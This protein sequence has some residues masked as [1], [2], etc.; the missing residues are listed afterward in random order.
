MKKIIT[1]ISPILIL[2]A[3]SSIYFYPA[4]EGKVVN[5]HDIVQYVGA[6]KET[7]DHRKEFKEEP[8]W[9]NGLFSGMPTYGIGTVYK[10]NYIKKIDKFLK[11][12]IPRPVSYLMLN[13]LGFYLL[14]LVMGCSRWLSL[15]GS[16]AF[17]LSS[18]FFIIIYAGHNT[19][20]MAIVYMA[21]VVMGLIITYR[22]KYW[23]GGIITAFAL[24]L[25]L[26]QS[27]P[28]ITYYLAFIVMFY[29]IFQFVE[30]YKNKQLKRFFKAS[31]ILLIAAILSLG[32][33]SSNY[34]VLLEYKA[35]STR[36]HSEL[37]DGKVSGLKE[38][39]SKETNYDL[40]YITAWSYGI[41]ETLTLMIPD[42]MG[43]ASQRTPG[44]ESNVY[45]KAVARGV[46]RH[47]AKQIANSLPMYW[48]KQPF[49]SGPVY[50]GAIIC[51]L[52]VF[53][54]FVVKGKYKWWLL[55]CTLFSIFI[56]WGHNMM[57]FI[58]PFIYYFP[59]FDSFRVPAMTLVISQFTVPLLGILALKEFF[60]AKNKTSFVKPL[61]NSLY[62]TA[63][64]CLAV[65]L[66]GSSVFDF[67][68]AGD[69]RLI[70]G[71]YPEWLIEA[72]REDRKEMMRSEAFRSLL[73]IVAGFASLYLWAKQRLKTK[74]VVVALGLL[75]IV[76]MWAVDKR[77]MNNGHFVAAK[78][79]NQ[80]FS[81]TTADRQILQ[82]ADP[83]Y[84][85]FNTTINSFNDNSASYFHKNVGGYSAVKLQRYQDLIEH[86]LARG[87]QKVF[88]M[89]NTKYFI[90]KGKDGQPQAVMNPKA[91]GNA[92]FV[93]KAT[94]ARNADE[95][96]A[97]LNKFAPEKEAVVDERFSDLLSN[98]S[99]KED[100]T[101]YI[102]LSSYKANH[103]IY[104]YA[105]S[106]AQMLVFSEIYYDKGWNLYVDGKL[107]PYFRANYVLRSAILPPGNHKIE[108]RFE[109]KSYTAG[110]NVALASF[111]L[112]IAA[113]LVLIFK[114]RRIIKSFVTKQN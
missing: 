108:W 76:D 10:H 107:H 75:V 11:L 97:M 12:G 35:E 111:L 67:A 113:L 102:N 32:I 78:K 45:K 7:S 99:Y 82:D 37:S 54:L 19:K 72:L 2:I 27:H 83:H 88:N 62:I 73:F 17:G 3:I 91:M 33:N 95:E 44:V 55:A 48:G 26:V 30:D 59:G 80:P 98:F 92:W 14:L 49:T 38:S 93:E 105:S 56:A 61:K 89:L 86:H 114:E 24:A 60:Q 94:M 40:N 109:P 20:A 46:S 87:N 42:L 96:I 69:S 50:Y 84:R 70:Q 18:Y 53:G 104:D 22:G 63:G 81:A 64:I 29:A 52:F 21:S 85:V 43:G 57:W 31:G 103:L 8:L 101:A 25:Q 77:Y 66:L 79:V 36:G 65:L 28:Q 15:I 110:A 112:L 47:Q 100:S 90:R 13:F 5:Q 1:T 4:F 34:F 41:P 9:T 16:L 74:H 71:G 68:G 106:V 58:K 51:F 6:S 39:G 23:W